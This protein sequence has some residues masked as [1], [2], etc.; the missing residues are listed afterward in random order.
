MFFIVK[1][2]ES[3]REVFLKM[4]LVFY[5][6]RSMVEL[7]GSEKSDAATPDEGRD[8]PT[9]P[10]WPVPNVASASGP[11]GMGTDRLFGLSVQGTGKQ[12]GVDACLSEPSGPSALELALIDIDF[13]Q[14]TGK[15]MGV[16]AHLSE[17]SGPSALNSRLIDTDY[18]LDDLIDDLL[19]DLLNDLLN[20]LPTDM[21]DDL[22]SCMQNISCGIP[23]DLHCE[24]RKETDKTLQFDCTMFTSEIESSVFSVC[25]PSYVAAPVFNILSRP[26][27]SDVFILGSFH[28]GENIFS[29]ESR[30]R[31]C[32]LNAMCSL[33]HANYSRLNCSKDL[34]NVLLDG[35]SL[36][37]KTVQ[38]LQ[39]TNRFRNFLL[40]FDE[41][42]V[43]II[44]MN[45]Q[46]SVTKLEVISGVCTQQ[47]ATMNLPSFYQS[48]DT[49]FTK[50]S[51]LLLM[52]GSVCSAVFKK[53]DQYFFFDSHSHGLTGLS[54]ENGT[55]ILI[56]FH[57][58]QDLVT[59]M[60]AL[61][62]SMLI[63]ITQ[64]FD[65]LPVRFSNVY[66]EPT[67]CL[68]EQNVE[69]VNVVAGTPGLNEWKTVTNKRKK[70]S[71]SHHSTA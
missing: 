70:K 41:L 49:A 67:M 13:E 45:K 60:Y 35:D 46:I 47:F 61:Y 23:S 58:L 44:I 7:N 66:C 40:N 2:F 33:I 24:T 68:S 9:G 28:Q 42:P 14:G 31:Q 56:S 11:S 63:D 37:K 26:A 6:F 39:R 52:M 8:D 20:D 22:T 55:S 59:Y 48:L 10:L 53:E 29:V 71:P 62:D 34:D 25:E 57:Q 1:H 69:S 32:T 16:D 38:E 12:M 36:Y 51:Y 54:S 17:P 65:L 15:Q 43:H 5:I 30:G 50:S 19:D 64:Q 27:G 3:D 18:K 4:Y 21:L